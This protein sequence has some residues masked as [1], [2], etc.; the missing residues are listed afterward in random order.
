MVSYSSKIATAVWNGKHDGSG[1][2]SSDNS[3][4]RRV[5]NDYM[6]TVHPNV[7][8]PA[9]KWNPG[10]QPAQPAGIHTMT[11][12]GVTDIWPSWYNEKTSGVS[13][14]T[15]QFN[16]Y[17]HKRAASC[18]N[19]DYVESIEI[20]KV[21]DPMTKKDVYNVPAGYD[22]DASDDCSYTA[23]HVGASYS[24]VT[25]TI[26]VTATGSEVLNGGTYTLTTAAGSVV[27]SGTIG[28]NTGFTPSY[29]VKGD[30]GTITVTVKDK[31]G[32]TDSSMVTI[33][34]QSSSSD[35]E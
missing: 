28:A 32:F 12:N 10:D 24:T 27:A 4:V 29:L 2:W 9:G 23:P 22:K 17:N 14:E 11:V 7:Y 19:P 1:L 8:Q 26:S 21:T 33:P 20:T 5:I 15:M 25:K 6:A 16:R 35:G 30:E 13:K 18:T 3:I 34:A 31:W